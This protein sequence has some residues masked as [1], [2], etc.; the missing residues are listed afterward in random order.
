MTQVISFRLDDELYRSL[1]DIPD[2]QD[3]IKRYIEYLADTKGK[4]SRS[5]DKFLDNYLK[6]KEVDSPVYRFIHIIATAGYIKRWDYS[7]T[8]AQYDDLTDEAK[9]VAD[10][11]LNEWLEIRE[12]NHSHYNILQEELKAIL[13]NRP[14]YQQFLAWMRKKITELIERNP[15]FWYIISDLI[16][17]KYDGKSEYL[18]IDE[19]M[20]EEMRTR[21]DPLFGQGTIDGWIKNLFNA[22]AAQRYYHDARKNQWDSI[23]INRRALD[24]IRHFRESKVKQIQERLATSLTDDFFEKLRGYFD[25]KGIEPYEKEDGFEGKDTDEIKTV[26]LKNGIIF[27]KKYTH[28]SPTAID[29]VKSYALKKV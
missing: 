10:T 9:L 6:G 19:E 16:H 3:M 20:L 5:I 24:E 29:I 17:Q 2:H 26:I 1:R 8:I 4:I 15:E 28:L 13:Y 22:G 11:I 14:Q 21:L 7:R 23:E 18:I 25:S 27:R 12:K